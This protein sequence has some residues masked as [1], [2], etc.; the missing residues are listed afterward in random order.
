[1]R[2]TPEK[3]EITVT[4]QASFHVSSWDLLLLVFCCRYHMIG[5]KESQYLWIPEKHFSKA[6]NQLGKALCRYTLVLVPP[7]LCSG[8]CLKPKAAALHHYWK[9]DSSESSKNNISVFIF[10]S[11]A[12]QLN[13]MSWKHIPLLKPRRGWQKNGD[14]NER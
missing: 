6:G 4:G 14:F 8:C 1:M 12:L 5:H 10:H 13:E 11:F 2:H 3:H 7:L 9:M